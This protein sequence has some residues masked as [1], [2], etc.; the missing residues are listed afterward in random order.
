MALGHEYDIFRDVEG[1]V[2]DTRGSIHSDTLRALVKP[3]RATTSVSI[4]SE[5]THTH[6]DTKPGTYNVMS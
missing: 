2:G 6:K 5:D 3:R 4:G 1:K